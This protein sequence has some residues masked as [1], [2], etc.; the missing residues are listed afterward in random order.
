MCSEACSQTRC[1][2]FGTEEVGAGEEGLALFVEPGY[3]D[4]VPERIEVGAALVE[5]FGEVGVQVAGVEGVAG[6]RVGFL[7]VE[8]GEEAVEVLHVG[9]VAAEADD[10]G[11]GE[12]AE[13]LDVGEAGEGSV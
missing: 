6:G 2:E 4:L 13:T 11:G 9:D 5:D 8:G 10:G 7:G 12:G 1:A 3:E